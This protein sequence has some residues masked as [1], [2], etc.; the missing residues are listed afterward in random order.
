M[1]NWQAARASARASA[2][3]SP[4]Q[5]AARVACRNSQALTATR[6]SAVRSVPQRGHVVTPRHA[7]RQV[8]HAMAAD[9]GWVAAGGILEGCSLIAARSLTFF[10]VEQEIGQRRH[11]GMQRLPLGYLERLFNLF[12]KGNGLFAILGGHL[13][14][15]ATAALQQGARLGDL[16]ATVAV[17]LC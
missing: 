1:C 4:A 3:R 2:V 7:A 15:Q 10:D 5:S 17:G 6:M 14:E 13:V 12:M 8:G 9:A 16:H 11:G